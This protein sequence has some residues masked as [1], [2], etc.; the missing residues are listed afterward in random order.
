MDL[1][2]EAETLHN[3]HF[4]VFP[5]DL[6]PF[7]PAVG[8]KIGNAWAAADRALQISAEA[9]ELAEWAGFDPD[10]YF[11][12]HLFG[13]SGRGESGG[14]S[15]TSV[16][17]MSSE[18]TGEDIIVIGVRDPG[19]QSGGGGG[20]GGGGGLTDTDTSLDTGETLDGPEPDCSETK[21]SIFGVTLDQ[22]EQEKLDTIGQA[23]NDL[24]GLIGDLPADAL[25]SSSGGAQITAGE[26]YQ[27]L[28]V[29]DWIISN[30]DWQNDT[31]HF[32]SDGAADRNDG[33]PIF[34]LK[35]SG[36]S[37]GQSP[38]YASFYVLHELAHVT[39]AGFNMSSTATTDAAKLASEQ[40]ANSMALLIYTT[41]FGSAP[42]F[43]EDPQG[44]YSTETF[45]YTPPANPSGET[46]E[47]AYGG[48]GGV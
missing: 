47:E 34:Y 1:F 17:T 36:L 29:A 27:L 40:W 8:P 14:S 22:E 13:E 33:N 18:N 38:E 23:A 2:G 48:C 12:S 21:A 42:P 35:E 39:L 28:I 9:R 11:L 25:F 3:H 6:I 7:D 16:V 31:E 43:G 10:V 30:Y 46:A 45:R 24:I 26:L 44:G 41:L 32:G 20:G 19:A 5:E 15:D 4:D 37:W